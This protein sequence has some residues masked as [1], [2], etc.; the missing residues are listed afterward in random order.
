MSSPPPFADSDDLR[1]LRELLEHV[2]QSKVLICVLSPQFVHRPYC[3]LEMLTAIDAGIPL[4][5]DA[6]AKRRTSTYDYAC[7]EDFLTH[8]DSQLD[9][10]IKALLLANGMPS[11]TDAAWKL[12]SILPK[13]I[14][15]PQTG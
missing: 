15:A 13:I 3:L 6:V 2:R 8:L 10:G 11:L 1:D 7:S 12:S 14:S 9:E 5:A 4:V